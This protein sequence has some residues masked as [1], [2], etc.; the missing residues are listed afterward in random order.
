VGVPLI[1]W[2][3]IGLLVAGTFGIIRT[4]PWKDD[5]ERLTGDLRQRVGDAVA[6][7]GVGPGDCDAVTRAPTADERS[8]VATLV[9]Q[10]RDNPDARTGS[11]DAASVRDAATERAGD[12]G[13]CLRD[14]TVRGAGW[15]DLQGKLNDGL[16]AAGR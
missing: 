9:R 15:A 12:I 8:A 3:V 13:E 16:A 10:L 11:G 1:K 14:V 6:T 7:L 5:V 2:I 4:A